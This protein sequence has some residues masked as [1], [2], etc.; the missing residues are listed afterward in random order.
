MDKALD[1]MLTDNLRQEFTETGDV[2]FAFYEEEAGRFRVNL[3]RQRGMRAMTLRHVQSRI[4]GREEL[5]LP[6]VVLKLAEYRSGIV[7][8]TGATGSGKSTSMACLLQHM[9]QNDNRHVVT[10]EDPIEYTFQDEGCIFEQREVGIDCSSFQSALRHVLRQDPDVII[11][12]EMRDRETFETAL[13]AA[14]TGHLVISTLHTR[15]AAQSLHRILDMYSSEEQAGVRQGLSENLRAIMCQ[16]LVPD[17]AGEGVVPAT[18]VLV[19]NPTVRSL[20]YENEMDKLDRAI[21]GG[22]DDGMISFNGSLLEL[23]N[24]GMITEETALAHTD[25]PEALRMNLRGIFLSAEG[26]IIGG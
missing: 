13:S 1:Q 3:H 18:E 19:N 8:V 15:T 7:F 5:H 16:R 14:E 25:S 4:P 26:G 11:I 10:V 23:I 2:D 9:N 21:E 12:G 24:E 17:A 20:I 6:H 22:G